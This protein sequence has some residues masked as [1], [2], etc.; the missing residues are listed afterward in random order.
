MAKKVFGV[1]II[2]P[3]RPRPVAAMANRQAVVPE[4]SATAYLVPH[5]LANSS[6]NAAMCFPPTN[7]ASASISLMSAVIYSASAACCRFR[8]R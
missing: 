4:F 1:V 6:S 3:P 5:R 7:Q 2:A 8:S